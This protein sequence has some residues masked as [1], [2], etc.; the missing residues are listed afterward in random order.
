MNRTDW[1]LTA[2][3]RGNPATAIDRRHSGVAWTEGNLVTTLVHGRHYFARL[4]EVL[5]RTGTHDIVLFTDWRGD[6]DEHLAGEGTDVVTVL[7]SLAERGVEVRGLI[8]KSHPEKVH[9]N[10]HENLRFAE[11]INEVGGEVLLD[12]RVRRAGSHHQKLVIVRHPASPDDD[13]AF[14]GG[15]D[16]CHGR[17]DD[18]NHRGDPQVT[19]VDARYGPT[20]GWHDMQVQLQGPAIGDLAE[21]FRERWADPAR[22]DRSPWRHRLARASHKPTESSRL[23]TMGR[24]PGAAGAHAVQVLRT[25]PSKQPPFPFAPEGERSIARAY[26]KAFRRARRLIYVEDQYLWSADVAHALGDAL[27]RNPGLR[28]VVVLPKYP[29]SDG[30]ISGPPNRIGQVHAIRHLRKA[31]G[32]RVAFYNLEGETWPI[33]VHAKIC[34]IDD[35]WMMVGSDNF[36]RRS[37][38]HDSELSCAILDETLDER[39]PIDPGGLGDRARVLARNTRL[40]LW[41]EHLGHRDVP[42]DPEHGFDMLRTAAH[43]LDAW[44]AAGK[45]GPRPAGRLRHHNPEPVPRATRALTK[46]FYR[47]V[48]DPDGRPWKLRFHRSY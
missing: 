29:D 18:E 35:V 5:Q 3:E 17:N 19:D 38:T 34:V 21:T 15:I 36:N 47:F 48:N 10:K 42:V 11:I 46:F 16:L 2:E 39:E 30:P 37:W 13:V 4:Y 28:L 7:K 22:L 6:P 40:A 14:V 24:D 41:E 31:G 25:Y 33:Y 45:V 32:S 8:W 26:A 44:H 1:F 23:P 27:R 43:A 9:F 12:E 20:P